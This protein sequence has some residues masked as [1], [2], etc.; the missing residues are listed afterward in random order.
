M[1][2]TTNHSLRYPENVSPV[3][4]PDDIKKL[5][6]DV[7]AK[8][9]SSAGG[10]VSGNVAFTGTVTVQ[11][12][13]LT[14]QAANKQYVDNALVAKLGANAAGSFATVQ[15][16]LDTHDH[17][18]ISVDNTISRYDGTTGKI[19]GSGVVIT[20][21]D[22]LTVAQGANGGYGFSGASINLTGT[23]APEGI[24]TAAPGSTY[25][26]TDATNDVKGWIKW[27]K[28]TGTGNTGWV[29][30]A[31]A[32]TGWRNVSGS[33]NAAWALHATAGVLTLRRVSNLVTL[34]GRLERV[35]ASGNRYEWSNV[36]STPNG[37]RPATAMAGYVFGVLGNGWSE[38]TRSQ[39]LMSN[40][41][42]SA[43]GVVVSGDAGTW[44]AGDDLIFQAQWVTSDAWPTSLPGTAA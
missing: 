10:T 28:A 31:E 40:L 38:F 43:V 34:T 20:D 9:I 25:L 29:A 15:Q 4:V 26:Q 11:T 23:G 14:N 21:N 35:T 3:A 1:G 27:V 39:V 22:R 42:D 44:A 17:P 36:Y 5:A 8:L 41:N 30:G 32:D 7:D 18:L 16:R 6:Q 19:Q 12:P 2:T 33:L 13:T 37:F 24:I